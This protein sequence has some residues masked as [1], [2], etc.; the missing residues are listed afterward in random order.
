VTRLFAVALLSLFGLGLVWAADP[1]DDDTPKAAATRKK[2]ETKVTV[3][4]K[5]EPLKDCL[6][7]L[8]EM[9]GVSIL[10]DSKGGVS[11]NMTINYEGKDVTL[12]EA[13]D[14][15]FKKNGLGYYV[16][17]GKNDAYDGSI[18]IKQGKERGFPIKD[19]EKDKPKDKKDK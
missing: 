12:A 18:W 15:M 11:G 16:R 19:E 3:K 5:D 2:L 10:I 13:L 6:D 8:K 4:F 17:S 14:G 1:K 9:A 7:E